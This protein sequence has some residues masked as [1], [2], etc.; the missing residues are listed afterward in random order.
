MRPRRSL[1]PVALVLA[2]LALG[3]TCPSFPPH[4]AVRV[5]LDPATTYQTIRGI[6][7]S[8]AD[9]RR[10]REMPEPERTQ[11]LDLVFG[12]LEPSVVRLK[13]RPG[14]EPANDNADPAVVDPAGF[15]R[16]DDLLWQHAEIHARGNPFLIAAMWTPPGWMKNTGVEN[17]GGTL[18][19]GLEPELAELFSVWLDYLADTGH[20]LDSLSIQNEPESSAP[21]DSNTYVPTRM[22]NVLETV[23]QRLVADGHATTLHGPDNAVASFMPLFLPPL[24]TQPTVVSRFE[25][26]AFHLYGATVYWD[27]STTAPDVQNVVDVAPPEYPLWMT[28]FSNTTFEGYGSHD[29]GIWQAEHIH[30]SLQMGVSLY[31]MWNLYRPGG[32]GE[33]AIV[34]PTQPGV[35]A[36]TITPKYWTLR[37]Y[38]KWVK[39]GAVRIEAASASAEVKVSA[40]RDAGAGRIVAVAINVAEE[41]RWVV[42]DGADLGDAPLVVRT[43]A[44]ENGVE[45]PLDSNERFGH[46]AAL[47]PARSVTTFAWA[48]E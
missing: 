6:G 3:S 43:S 46:R 28:E 23:A 32:P 10:L 24:L 35:P 1:L 38:T 31:A 48:V 16:P 2:S 22:D 4:P 11:V 29:E 14:I 34:I 7:G 5:A 36:Y 26:V 19:A 8:A 30:E 20:P 33:A 18:L 13:V 37:Q 42:F 40:F 25:A 45:L 39:P 41:P 44:A 21:W 12:D 15:V 47:L 17:G 27:A 9:E